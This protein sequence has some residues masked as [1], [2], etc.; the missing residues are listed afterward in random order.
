MRRLSKIMFVL[1]I[2]SFLSITLSGFH[3]HADIG[4][5]DE[6]ASLDHDHH[7]IVPHDP[8]EDVD[9]VDLSL[10]DPAPG[11]SKFAA[12]PPLLRISPVCEP[13]LVDIRWS[14]EAPSLVPPRNSRSRPALR[15]PPISV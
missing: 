15:G 11:F 2:I 1:A 8:E 5:H 13:T 7:K 12:V 14:T 3:I 6:A 9:H 4:A 10:F